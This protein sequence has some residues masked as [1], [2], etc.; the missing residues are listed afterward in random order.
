MAKVEPRYS[1]RIDVTQRIAIRRR[2]CR[3]AKRVAPGIASC[4]RFIVATDVVIQSGLDIDVLAGRSQV[5][6]VTSYGGRQRFIKRICLERQR[7]DRRTVQED[8]NRR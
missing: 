4:C 1:Q 5:E 3:K 6:R 7:L 8:Q 2:T